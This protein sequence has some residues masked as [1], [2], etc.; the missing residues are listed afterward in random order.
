MSP[1]SSEKPPTTAVEKRATD[2]GS[3]G[4]SGPLRG[5]GTDVVAALLPLSG[6]GGATWWL[7]NLPASYLLQ[8]AGMYALMG[9]LLL[10]ERT[11]ERE[12]RGLGAANR[13][14]LARATIVLP[15]AGLVFHSGVNAPAMGWWVVLW[16]TLAFL[17]DHLDGRVARRTGTVSAF[18]AR[19]D[20]ELDAF[21]I[22]ALSVL[23]WEWGK[24]GAW[25]LLIGA[26][27]YL[28]VGAGLVRRELNGP[29]PESQRRKIVC[30]AQ[31]VALLACLAPVVP[32]DAA[33]I[34][35]GSALALLVYSFAV[36]VRWLL[37]HASA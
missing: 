21:L 11:A 9:A 30:V 29:L 37:R 34:L 5:A 16:A 8:V 26:L 1:R 4:A 27:R 33:S 17:L 36:D 19:F 25:V 6:L 15:L 28:F 31:G 14:T 18:G 35:A 10:R 22:L 12:H 20:M 24:V 3:V 23:V 7:F 2:A 32:S 13:I